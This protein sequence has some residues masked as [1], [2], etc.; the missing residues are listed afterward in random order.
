MEL[1]NRIIQEN[2]NRQTDYNSLFSV[3]LLSL[4]IFAVFC[5][6]KINHKKRN[7]KC[8]L[9]LL[10]WDIKGWNIRK[11]RNTNNFTFQNLLT[12]DNKMH[13]FKKNILNVVILD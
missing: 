6:N 5:N 11:I 1:N 8:L 2:H 12:K 4:Q 3:L 10:S 7:I 13:L 9:R